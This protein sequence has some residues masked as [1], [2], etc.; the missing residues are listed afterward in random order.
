MAT[1]TQCYHTYLAGRF[2]G[3]PDDDVGSAQFYVLGESLRKALKEF[4]NEL[5]R[6]VDEFLHSHLPCS[7]FV[8]RGITHHHGPAKLPRMCCQNKET[9]HQPDTARDLRRPVQAQPDHGTEQET[10]HR[11]HHVEYKTSRPRLLAPDPVLADHC[12]V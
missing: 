6:I 3:G 2:R 1:P 12:Q 4:G 10:Q 7:L 8:S 11:Q 5:L 9:H